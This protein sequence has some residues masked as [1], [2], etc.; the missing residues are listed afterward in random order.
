MEQLDTNNN[1]T[2]MYSSALKWSQSVHQSA[3]TLFWSVS[4]S[5]CFVVLCTSLYVLYTGDQRETVYTSCTFGKIDN[6]V[7]F[8]FDLKR[9][10][11]L[12]S[13]GC[14]RHLNINLLEMIHDA[15]LTLWRRSGFIEVIKK[16]KAAD[17]CSIDQWSFA[18]LF[19]YYASRHSNFLF[20]FCVDC[21]GQ[22]HIQL[23]HLIANETNPWCFKIIYLLLI[24]LILY[25]YI[26]ILIME[27]DPPGDSDQEGQ[28][29]F[30]LSFPSTVFSN[31]TS[32][33]SCCRY[34][35]FMSCFCNYL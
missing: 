22:T 31:V 7:D 28:C 5:S 4:C 32:W 18:A 21:L 27:V 12:P 2:E 13:A 34:N 29:F 15:T 14:T 10:A 20:L 25:I 9:C 35:W 6:K 23:K 11:V 17:L 33:C 1:V 30:F 26:Y 3:G 24:I 16:V 19:T 8:A